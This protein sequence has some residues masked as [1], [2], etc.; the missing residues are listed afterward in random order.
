MLP[1]ESL[2]KRHMVRV[3]SYYLQF[4]L[5][6]DSDSIS[7]SN[8]ITT[9]QFRKWNP[10]INGLCDNLQEGDYVCIGAPGGSYIPPRITKSTTNATAQQPGGNGTNTSN[11]STAPY[12]NSTTPTSTLLSQPS[13]S[14]GSNPAPPSPTQKDISTS[15]TKY[16]QAKHGDYCFTF[17]QANNI[18]FTQLYALN[19]V[20]G[21]A[22][23]FC[24][25]AFWSGYYYC[26]ASS[27]APALGT[28]NSTTNTTTNS[29]TNSTPI[30][31]TTPSMITTTVSTVMSTVIATV[32][33]T[34]PFTT[35]F[36]TVPTLANN[37]FSLPSPIQSGVSSLCAKYAQAHPGDTCASF[38][39]ANG[40]QLIDLYERNTALGTH[41]ENCGTKF[42][43]GYYYCVGGTD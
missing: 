26:V 6:D 19:G 22:G 2:T 23:E 36:P 14:S 7:T 33:A 30:A 27:D 37:A 8:S 18:A 21:N 38:A 32:S 29:T 5:T 16:S 10:N 35:L 4:M 40:I 12:R 24:S 20:L 28:S 43:A 31:T 1:N 42:W 11:N 3:F 17:A 39:V 41:G 9:L 25:K 34:T 13:G 15:C